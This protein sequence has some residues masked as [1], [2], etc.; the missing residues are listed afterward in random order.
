VNY[1]ILAISVLLAVCGQV[2]MKKG[3]MVF[4]TFPATE[5]LFKLIPMF[6]NPWVFFG[7]ACFGLSSIFWLIVLSRVP[8]SQ[9]YPMVS[10]AYVLTALIS[11]V[12]FKET[13]GALRWAGIFV[14]VFGVYL[15]SRS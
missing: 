15:I 3:M 10:V 1:I 2:L 7:F 12:F 4:G 5:I 6:M 11:M 13:V 14:I 9:A 8:L